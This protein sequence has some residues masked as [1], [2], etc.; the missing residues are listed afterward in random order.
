MV[1]FEYADDLGD[2]EYPDESDCSDEFDED[3]TQT[4]R[5]PSC[6]AEIYEDTPQCTYCGH[7]I[8]RDDRL[9]RN[10]WWTVV[11]IVVLVSFLLWMFYAANF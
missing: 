3:I 1:D 9:R 5:C 6:G 10:G 4:V 7:Y 11:L 2:D 8:T